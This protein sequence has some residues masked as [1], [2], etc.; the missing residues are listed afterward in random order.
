[1]QSIW[2]VTVRPLLADLALPP[3]PLIIALIAAWPLLVRKP[4]IG[5]LL[6]MAC[7]VSLWLSSSLGPAEFASQ[8]LL[9]QYHPMTSQRLDSLR[10]DVKLHENT[11]IIALG[12]G[13]QQFA[14]EYGGPKLTSES[15]ERLLYAIWLGRQLQLP[16]GFSGG[17]GWAAEDGL[18]EAIAARDV[19]RSEFHVLLR[20][21]ESR[22]RD[23]RQNASETV[24]LLRA[25]GI[26]RV[27]LVTSTVHMPRAM[28]AF[29]AAT[30]GTSMVVEPAPIGAFSSSRQRV[31][32]WIPSGDGIALMRL[33]IREWLWALGGA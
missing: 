29:E 11:G 18:A 5:R 32:D 33:V 15:L 23:T 1:M 13:I 10:A 22:S 16:V 9:R 25:D 26:E 8:V 31:F 3:V 2:I 17:L 14:P 4:L 28:A 19:A 21:V 6:M 7:A 24:A 20:W 27:V 30:K 12:S